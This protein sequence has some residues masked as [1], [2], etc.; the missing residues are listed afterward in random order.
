MH[1]LAH[2]IPSLTLFLM[3]CYTRRFRISASFIPLMF[4]LCTIC[5]SFFVQTDPIGVV[6][7]ILCCNQFLLISSSRGLNR[8]FEQCRP[9]DFCC[10]NE[11]FHLPSLPVLSI[12]IIAQ[13]LTQRDI[14]LPLLYPNLSFFFFFWLGYSQLL[15]QAFLFKW[16]MYLRW[17]LQKGKNACWLPL[18]M[19][20]WPGEMVLTGQMLL[21]VICPY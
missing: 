5:V 2:A 8:V 11:L 13:P 9:L 7:S 19:T 18:C 17:H 3:W 6:E 16:A 1:L 15:N 4:D 20:S 14:V 21:N 10:N 12:Q